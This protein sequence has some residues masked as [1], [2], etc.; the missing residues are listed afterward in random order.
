[1]I[2]LGVYF[3]RNIPVVGA[4]GEAVNIGGKFYPTDLV[5][6]FMWLLTITLAGAFLVVATRPR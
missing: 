6:W 5:L 4:V 1:M 2:S 3:H